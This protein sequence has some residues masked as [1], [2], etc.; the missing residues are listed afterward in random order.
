LVQLPA[1]LIGL[2]GRPIPLILG[3]NKVPAIMGTSSA[4]LNYWRRVKPDPKL[5]TAMALPAFLLSMLG[6]HLASHFP[7][8]AFRPLL[9]ALLICVGIYT[10]RKKALGLH[11]Q[12]KYTS[13]KRYGIVAGAGAVIGLYDG[14]IGP[15]TGTF[16]LFILVTVVGYEF[17]RASATAKLVNIAT[18]LA[19]IFIFGF[20]GH[21]WWR[22][23]LLLGIANISGALLGARLAL[24]GG[25]LLVRRTFLIVTFVLIARVGYDWWAHLGK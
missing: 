2:S 17:L 20:G 23:G 19:A 25:S 9:L 21:I 13:G 1:L 8:Q 7:A 6:A 18:N 4:A 11:E 15:G 24:R 10:W 5:A 16:L 3:T 14:M 12:L 22:L